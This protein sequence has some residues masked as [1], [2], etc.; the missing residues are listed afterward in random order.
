MDP[1][2]ERAHLVAAL[3]RQYDAHLAPH[4][5]DNSDW[6]PEWMNVVCVHLPTGQ[7]AWHMALEDL[8]LFSHLERRAAHWDMHTTEEKYGR[9]AA[10]HAS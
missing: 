1:Y 10:L 7:A 9:L 8:H 4:Q 3:S 2:T 5:G 6:D